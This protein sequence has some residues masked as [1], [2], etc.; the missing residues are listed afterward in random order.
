MGR[1][2]SFWHVRAISVLSMISNPHKCS[3]WFHAAVLAPQSQMHPSTLWRRAFEQAVKSGSDKSCCCTDATS[4]TKATWRVLGP[5]SIYRSTSVRRMDACCLTAKVRNIPATKKGCR[6]SPH[7]KHREASLSLST[8]KVSC[9]VHC[10]VV[11]LHGQWGPSPPPG[12]PWCFK[13]CRGREIQGPKGTGTKA[14]HDLSGRNLGWRGWPKSGHNRPCTREYAAFQGLCHLDHQDEEAQGDNLLFKYLNHLEPKSIS[15]L[16]QG[17][18]IFIISVS[19]DLSL[20]LPYLAAMQWLWES[21]FSTASIVWY[22]QGPSWT[23]S[24][25]PCVHKEVQSIVAPQAL[26]TVVIFLLHL[27]SIRIVL[28]G[29]W[30][31]DH[32]S[33]GD[34]TKANKLL[35]WCSLPAECLCSTSLT[36]GRLLV[37]FNTEDILQ[38]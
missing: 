11:I 19:T 13:V 5:P 14:C 25:T 29:Y 10:L 2:A 18:S 4:R 23:I 17:K 28:A 35:A 21:G 33:R 3:I 8:M 38:Y 32:R 24:I 15:R 30:S 26:T 37:L 1:H 22:S 16:K 6:F 12:Y 36:R 20:T 31:N 34:D 7:V 27:Y 9:R